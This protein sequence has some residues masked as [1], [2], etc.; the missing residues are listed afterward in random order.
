L[1][2][3]NDDGYAFMPDIDGAGFGLLAVFYGEGDGCSFFE[4]GVAGFGVYFCPLECIGVD[5][6]CLFV[7][8]QGGSGG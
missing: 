2:V 8:A 5:F 7:G 4:E 6:E 3:V 1:G